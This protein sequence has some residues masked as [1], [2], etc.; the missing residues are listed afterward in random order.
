[1]LDNWEEFL[2]SQTE[3]GVGLKPPKTSDQKKKKLEVPVNIH[4]EF[5]MPEEI[6]AKTT[7]NN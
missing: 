7:S 5:L 3:L 4:P 2:R 1:M 6:I